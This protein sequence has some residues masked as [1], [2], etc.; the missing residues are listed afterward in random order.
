ME[1]IIKPLQNISCVQQ[2]KHNHTLHSSQSVGA[3]LTKKLL[4]LQ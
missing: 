1:G 4:K 3:N 2:I